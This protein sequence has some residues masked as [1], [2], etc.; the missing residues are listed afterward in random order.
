MYT[1]KTT[2]IEWL[3]DKN[4]CA[5]AIPHDLGWMGHAKFIDSNKDLHWTHPPVG[6]YEKAI[7]QAIEYCIEFVAKELTA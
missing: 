1:E 2:L 4:L 3:R 6:S 7:S 5:Y